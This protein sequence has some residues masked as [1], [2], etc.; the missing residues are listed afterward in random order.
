MDTVGLLLTVAVNGADVDDAS[1]AAPALG[2]LTANEFPRL[3]L[4]WT[5]NNYHNYP[6]YAWSRT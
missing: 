3:V 2:P 6:L 1:A 5:G 4:L